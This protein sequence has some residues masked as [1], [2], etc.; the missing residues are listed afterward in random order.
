MRVCASQEQANKMSDPFGDDESDLNVDAF[1]LLAIDESR[2][3]CFG[4]AG[5]DA[6]TA[7]AAAAGPA[8]GPGDAA[9]AAWRAASAGAS[10]A[11]AAAETRAGPAQ[12]QAAATAAATAT[13]EVKA[14]ECTEDP[15]QVT[16]LEPELGLY[17]HRARGSSS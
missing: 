17:V 5:A 13:V 9:E 7:A 10:G 14:S 3:L 2:A 4:E 8:A 15:D 16:E 11:Q 6:A 1:V 12:A